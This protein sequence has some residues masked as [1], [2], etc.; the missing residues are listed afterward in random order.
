MDGRHVNDRA[1]AESLILAGSVFVNGQQAAYAGEPVKADARIAVKGSERK[2]AGKGGLKL[3]G[4]LRHFRID[5]TG[6]IALDAG[7]STGGF[8]DCL[9]QHGAAQVY[10]VD[11]GYGQLAG[12]LRQDRR[13]VCMEKLNI[14]QLKP[15][16]LQPKPSLVT[17]DLSY[18]SLKQ[19]IPIAG[20]LMEPD[21]QMLCL[22]KPLFEINDP[23]IRRTGVIA[24]PDVYREI[25]RDL[26]RRVRELGYA[27]SGVT[28][29]PVTG[30]RGTRE[31]FLHLFLRGNEMKP[32]DEDIDQAVNA[33][34]AIEKYR[35]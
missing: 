7:A 35:K 15:T 33:A 19:A 17:L 26:V 31:F 14:G 9:L 32:L 16:M 22:V 12:R 34:L 21:G 25:L 28:H 5:V 30:N 27:P 24:S 29:S 3:E 18:L 10:A 8:T 4:A 1:Q 2:Y 20:A 6:R 13:V 23:E 11:V